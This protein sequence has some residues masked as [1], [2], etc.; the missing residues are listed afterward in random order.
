[1]S[2]GISEE[3]LRDKLLK[4]DELASSISDINRNL[5]NAFPKDIDGN[6]DF[7]GHRQHHRKVIESEKDTNKTLLDFKKSV[8]IWASIGMAS[9]ILNATS[10][11]YILPFL[12]KVFGG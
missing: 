10:S 6:I 3:V 11:T 5:E 1:M 9:I 8:L 2:T 12:Q 4:I 7:Y